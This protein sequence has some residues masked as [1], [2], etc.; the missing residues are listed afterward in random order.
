MA[1]FTVVGTA[2]TID[3]RTVKHALT[4]VGRA[5]YKMRSKGYTRADVEM[6][7]AITRKKPNTF[8]YARWENCH[9][10]VPSYC[11]GINSIVY[12]VFQMPL[13]RYKEPSS[14]F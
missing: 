11:S 6:Q 3:K 13:C 4:V 5:V 14:Y 10:L 7:R 9:E 2:C 1:V 8:T 12:A